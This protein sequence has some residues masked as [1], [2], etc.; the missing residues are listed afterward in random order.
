VPGIRSG[1]LFR[2]GER[3]LLDE[4]AYE[5]LVGGRDPVGM[6]VPVGTAI[7]IDPARRALSVSLR[8]E[9]AESA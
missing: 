2:S 7:D 4:A 1:N 9:G 3:Q 6:L 5:Q 8:I